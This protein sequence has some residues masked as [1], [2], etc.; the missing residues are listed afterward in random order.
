MPAPRRSRS[1]SGFLRIARAAQL[2][3]EIL[4]ARGRAAV[5]RPFERR[6]ARED[7]RVRVRVGRGDAAGG[8]GGDVQLVIGAEDQR[9]ADQLRRV[10]HARRPGADE[11][12]LHR[13]LEL[14]RRRGDAREEVHDAPAG[15]RDS[16]RAEVERQRIARG[17]ERQHRLHAVQEREVAR[18]LTAD[19]VQRRVE[20]VC[21]ERT[22]PHQRGHF[23][24]RPRARQLRSVVAAV[25]E[26]P[27]GDERDRRLQDRHA[28]AERVRRRFLRIAALFR[29]DAKPL[30]VLARIA[31][32][33]RRPGTGSERT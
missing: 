18:A 1:A 27:V 7:D 10:L 31:A 32:L 15:L 21:V 33:P 22:G 9:G 28:P 12:L 14:A 6:E 8:E 25:V 20:E 23:F 2:F 29:A 3:E 24:Q 11:R 30:D 5:L 26:L 13:R 19:D 17:D 16:A 4:D